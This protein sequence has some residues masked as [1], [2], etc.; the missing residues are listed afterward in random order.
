MDDLEQKASKGGAKVLLL[1]HMRGKVWYDSTFFSDDGV[2][3]TALR[4]VFVTFS[5]HR[6]VEGVSKWMQWDVAYLFTA[7]NPSSAWR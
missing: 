1:S 3:Y 2:T 5:W 7:A 4:K 6:M